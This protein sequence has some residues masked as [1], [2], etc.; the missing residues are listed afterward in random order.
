MTRGSG[1]CLRTGL[2]EARG[3]HPSCMRHD[4]GKAAGG[5][6]CGVIIKSLRTAAAHS[7][8]P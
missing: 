8:G 7:Q 2:V 5:A 1:G 4:D 6:E 3:L